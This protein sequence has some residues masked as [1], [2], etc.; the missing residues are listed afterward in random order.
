MSRARHKNMGHVKTFVYYHHST[1][2]LSLKFTR[3]LNEV[4]SFPEKK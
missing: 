1:V 4:A 2:A 3:K